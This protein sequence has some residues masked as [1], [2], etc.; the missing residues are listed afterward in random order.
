MKIRIEAHS[1]YGSQ[2][3]DIESIKDFMEYIYDFIR[4]EFTEL[5]LKHTDEPEGSKYK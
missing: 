3:E 4:G 2:G 5:K 1:P